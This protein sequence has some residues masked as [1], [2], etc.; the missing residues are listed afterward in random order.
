M[1]RVWDPL[2][3]LFHWSLV[4][5]IAIAWLTTDAGTTWH[6]WI[7]YAAL[8]LIGFRIIWGLIGPRYARFTQFIRSPGEVLSYS[9]DMLQKREKRYIGHNPLGAVMVVVLLL[10]T[11]ATG[12]TGW[13]M[14]EPERL[15]S[16]PDM[17]AF[18]TSAFADEDDGG[19]YEYGESDNEGAS[20]V[21][22]ETHEVLA[23]L[24]LLLIFLHIGG[25]IYASYR[26][27]EML[28]LA[29]TT[30]KKPAPGPDDIA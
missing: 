14:T 10:T 27:K 1:I 22:E 5:S 24:L 25:V 4:A 9:R 23:N 11:A 3:R 2:L 12:A 7:G 28:P 26:H 8:G 16:L 13:L 15:A 17:P 30:G 21:L 19:K 6:A 20:E 29:M 18:V